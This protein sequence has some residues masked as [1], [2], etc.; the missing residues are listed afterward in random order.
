MNKPL[1]IWGLVLLVV[2]GGAH[3]LAAGGYNAAYLWVAVAVI[4]ILLNAWTGKQMKGAPKG[5]AQTW[6]SLSVFGLLATLA[7]VSGL[8]P[9]A[10]PVLMSLWLLLLGA[11]IFSE[12]HSRN[13]QM[14][15]YWGLVT[16]FSALFIPAFGQWYFM[17]GALFLG[18]FGLINGYMSK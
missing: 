9:L 17:A 18:L 13:G 16:A 7:V 2:F 10:L 11:A 3:Y 1:T 4:I 6:M 14:S 8:L 5:S 15:V 12:G